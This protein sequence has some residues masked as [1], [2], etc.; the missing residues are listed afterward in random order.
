METTVI[1]V[2]DYYNRPGYY[3]FMHQNLFDILEAAFLEDK[4]SVEVPQELFDT[5]IINLNNSEK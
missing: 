2:L 5:M 3:P 4:I 1:T